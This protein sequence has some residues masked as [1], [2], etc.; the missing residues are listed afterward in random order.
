MLKK[1]FMVALA[2]LV[3]N[4][5]CAAPVAARQQD[6]DAK[7]I[8]KV[9]K[10]IADL[11]TGTRAKVEVKLRDKTKLAGYVSEITDDHFAVTDEKTNAATTVEYAQVEKVR[12]TPSL[13]SAVRDFTN[14][15]AGKIVGISCGIL[16]G[17][18]LVAT[19]IL[20][21]RE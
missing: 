2:G 4:L 16:A 18:L 1:L 10:Q 7:R 5:A 12:P 3:L 19:L 11:G 14:T 21:P 13:Q 15:R 8:A 9:K 6:K 20:A 17:V